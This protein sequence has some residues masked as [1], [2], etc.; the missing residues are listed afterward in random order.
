MFKKLLPVILL[1]LVFLAC[2]SSTKFRASI[3]GEIIAKKD[4]FNVYLTF[5]DS[6]TGLAAEDFTVTGGT[7]IGVTGEGLYHTALIRA[8]TPGN[9]T[10]KLKPGAVSSTTGSIQSNSESNT[11]TVNA[12]FDPLLQY[13]N[14][15]SDGDWIANKEAS[16]GLTF[17]KGMASPSGATGSFTSVTRTFTEEMKAQSITL[18][19][20]DVWDNWT[21]TPA[22][23]GPAD[24][25][26]APVLLTPADGEYYLFGEKN[27]TVYKVWRSSNM[28]SW[29][30]L[31]QV[32]DRRWMT[33]AEYA[34][35]VFYSIL[36]DTNDEDPALFVDKAID[37]G[38]LGTNHGMVFND[39]SHGSDAAIIQNR[40]KNT[41]CI[42]R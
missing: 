12:S 36:D 7:V 37:D 14:V 39:P 3:Y 22:N 1:T 16:T 32:T 20:S 10:V 2:N 15:K 18:K 35:G 13:W 6:V 4:T 17:N 19:Q 42:F 30:E 38:N 26:D 21:K 23:I 40:V 5:G 31:D 41:I 27:G 9:V 33:S 28:T 11:H 34:D 24:A 29:V 8:S 25:K